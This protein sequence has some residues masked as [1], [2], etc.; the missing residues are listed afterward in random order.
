MKIFSRLLLGGIMFIGSEL[1][2]ADLQSMGQSYRTM[3]ATYNMM[4]EIAERCPKLN[5]PELPQ[6]ADVDQVLQN[7]L[8]I[9]NYVKVMLQLNRS[10]Y[11]KEAVDF[12]NNLL[13]Q[14]DGCD[15]PKMN[16]LLDRMAETYQKAY[17]SF[18]ADGLSKHQPPVSIPLK[19]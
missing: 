17:D 11:K 18:L 13:D 7:R 5:L 16:T 9:D 2:F 4:P 6:K 19:K 1:V 3:L 15:D 12:I 8:G 14:A 10:E